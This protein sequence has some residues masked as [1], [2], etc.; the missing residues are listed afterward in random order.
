[1]LFVGRLTPHKGNDLL[2][3]AIPPD[4]PLTVVGTGGQDP[5]PPESGCSQLLAR[6]ADARRCGL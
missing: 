2:I 6:L 4:V 1:M 5:R 3:R